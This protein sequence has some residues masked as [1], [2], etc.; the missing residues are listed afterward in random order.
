MSIGWQDP[1]VARQQRQRMEQ[2]WPLEPMDSPSQFWNPR[3]I[4][5]VSFIIVFTICSLI[6]AIKF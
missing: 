2:H 3:S 4:G 1:H 5:M 6:F